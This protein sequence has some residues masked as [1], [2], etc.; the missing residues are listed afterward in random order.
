MPKIDT[1][2]PGELSAAA[3]D[4]FTRRVA[5]CVAGYAVALAVTSLG[6]NNATK[7][8]LLA[9]QQASNQWAYYQAKEIREHQYR[10]GRLR[11]DFD[12]ASRPGTLAGEIR[13]QAADLSKTLADEE[14]RYHDEKGSIEAEAKLLEA[15]RD[16]NLAKD[17]YFDYAEVLWQIAIVV[18]SVA[19]L[20]VSRPAFLFS[21]ALAALASLLMLNGFT[22]LVKLPFLS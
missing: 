10:I 4:S 3:R 15:V 19:I 9:Q 16:R 17:P 7:E 21:A 6:G 1:P 12:L 8:M 2:D 22:L 13:S 20:A 14:Q 5:L 11:L 18:A